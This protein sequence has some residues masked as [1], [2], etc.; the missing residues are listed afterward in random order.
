[1]TGCSASKKETEYE[2]DYVKKIKKKESIAELTGMKVINAAKEEQINPMYSTSHDSTYL[3]WLNNELLLLKNNSKCNIFA[4][5]VLFKSG[6]RYPEENVLTY[7]LMD[8][9]K[10]TDILPVIQFTD[11]GDLEKGDLI[12]WNGHVIIYEST[13]IMNGEQY[14]YAWWAG[15]RQENDGINVI[16][17]VAHGKYPLKGDF[18]VRRPLLK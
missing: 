7:D 17:D 10:F 3:Y 14:A 16:N 2:K 9:S 4:M 1:M 13:V 8:T 5:N 15:S 18:I 6:C 11:E 12:V